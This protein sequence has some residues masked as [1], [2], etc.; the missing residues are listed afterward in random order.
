MFFLLQGLNFSTAASLRQIGEIMKLKLNPTKIKDFVLHMYEEERS[1]ATVSKY[2]HDL[3]V[4]RAF[5]GEQEFEKTEVLEYK[6]ML[7]TRYAVTSANSMIAALNS[8]FRF[9]NRRDLCVRQYKIQKSAFCTEERELTR[10]EYVRLLESAKRKGNERLNLIIQTIC[11]SGI[12]VSE[13]QFITK[14]A[15][16]RGEAIVNCKGKNRRIFKQRR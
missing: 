3:Q 13:L 12:R 9:I 4:F 5:I 10:S 7:L 15:V 6:K 8:F 2:L 11:A 14:E 16:K 1:S